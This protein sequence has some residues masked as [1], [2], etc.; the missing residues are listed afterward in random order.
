MARVFFFLQQAQLVVDRGRGL[1]DLG[2]RMNDFTRLVLAT[3]IEFW[4][5]RC[6]CAPHSLLR[7][8]IDQTERIF[9]PAEP[10][11]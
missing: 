1:L 7:R 5:E 3:D 9:F 8:D 10:P 4:I 11:P 2:Q 6:V